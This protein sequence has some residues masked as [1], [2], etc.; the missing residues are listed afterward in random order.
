MCGVVGAYHYVTGAPVSDDV[1]RA[2]ASRIAHRGP[3][4]EGFFVEGAIG[5]GHR[6][7]A[8]IDL[9]SGQ[10]PMSDAEGEL[11]VSYN[12][13]IYNFLELRD[14]LETLGHRFRTHSDTEVLL[15][16][17]ARWGLECVDHFNG[18]FAFALWDGRNRRLMLARDRLGIKPLYYAHTEDGVVFGSELKALRVVPG[19]GH[20][21]DLVAVDEYLTCGYV[22][23][24]R[25]IYSAIRKLEPGTVMVFERN[26]EPVSRRYWQLAFRPDFD[27][28]PQAWHEAIVEA[29]DR[30]VRLQLRSDVP[31]GTLLSGGVDS[32]LIASTMARWGA[33]GENGI[34]SYCVG[35]DVADAQNEYRFSSEVAREV[36]TTHHELRVSA[37]ELGK[38]T[39]EAGAL[40]DEPL[41][42]PMVGQLLAICRHARDRVTVLLSGEGADETWFGYPSYRIHGAIDLIQ[43]AIPRPLLG[44][45]V[46]GLNAV[47]HRAPVP[48]KVMKH[49]RNLTEPLE[50]RYLGLSH[51]DL[52][53]KDSLR[54]PALRDTLRDHDSREVM[55]RFF[56]NEAGGPESLSR[57]AAIDC[58]AWLVDNT[59]MRS[60][61]MSMAASLELRVP[62]LD[63]HLVELATSVP[64]RLKV[65][66][67]DQKVI[68]KRALRDRLPA[69]VARR[70]K[71]GFPTP[72]VQLYRGSF[73]RE[74]ASL[75]S[76]PSQT[77]RE[78]IDHR[79][80]LELYRAHRD[81]RA[82]HSYVLHQMLM[83]ELWGRH[84]ESRP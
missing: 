72:L 69:M 47:G 43:R 44:L 19:I 23:G 71:A 48:A 14:E 76:E 25:S 21:V 73:G 51:F 38:L 45:F 82:N 7:L 37:D 33:G 79:H 9:A 13:E 49:A 75:W 60:D 24:P 39:L 1:L 32:T 30:S 8:V 31:L 17:Y 40:L 4:G 56:A 10:Q 78:L 11:W 18:M 81:G 74:A 65:Q 15:A 46:A 55:R 36:G 70:R 6:R 58:R 42:E 80:V 26:R 61:L 77:T 63:H 41:V 5:L 3:D 84:H 57:M 53:L 34:H 2:M 12:G 22:L 54:G 83:L 35:V 68:L 67:N 29:F 28:S 27:R 20:E 62:F 66:P 50:R 59:L 16:A 64:V 52:S